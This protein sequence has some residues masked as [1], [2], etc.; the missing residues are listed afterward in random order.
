VHTSS[1]D[2]QFLPH[3]PKCRQNLTRQPVTVA[4]VGFEA[5]CHSDKAPM[6]HAGTPA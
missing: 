1:V 2:V 5:R 6:N 4:A 3:G